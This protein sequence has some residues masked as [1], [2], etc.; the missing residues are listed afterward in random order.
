MNDRGGYSRSRW[1]RNSDM[2]LT[3]RK[4]CIALLLVVLLILPLFANQREYM[5][6]AALL[7]KFPGFIKWPPE[8]GLADTSKPFIIG[9]YGKNPIGDILEKSYARR[10]IKN[11]NVQVKY[12]ST[13][14]GIDQ[15]H[16]LFI[17]ETS[18]KTLSEILFI[19]KNKPVLTVGVTPG[20]AQKGVHINIYSYFIASK[21]KLGF[22]INP[23]AMHKASLSANASLFRI[24][25]IVTSGKENLR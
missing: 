1:D 21:K 2:K 9:I 16:M 11:K 17:S 22:E 12:F 13:P 10:K 8:S 19:V 3:K 20:Y 4:T 25:K 24:G 7:G 18:E 14:E 15:C 5:V 6:K 23:I